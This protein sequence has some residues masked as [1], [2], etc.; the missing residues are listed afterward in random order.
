MEVPLKINRGAVKSAIDEVDA[1]GVNS[2][3][4]IQDIAKRNIGI[5]TDI[6]FLCKPLT[7]LNELRVYK[8]FTAG[9][10]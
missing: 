8:W 10:M 5:Y 9:Q 1:G 3:G 4:K 2:R 7:K 6:V